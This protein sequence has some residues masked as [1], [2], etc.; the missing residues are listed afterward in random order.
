[1]EKTSFTQQVRRNS[2]ALLSL[3]VALSAL[4]YN[5]WR[6]EATERNRNI[7]VAEFEMLKSLG[8]L[9]QIIDYAHFRR[10]PQRGDL[11]QGLGR[12]LQIHDLATLTPKPVQD[13]AEGLLTAWRK[14]DE[15][16]ATDLEAAGL[17]SEEILHTRRTVLTSLRSLK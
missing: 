5:T 17:I 1:M 11:T 6:N 16:L 15:K 3:C 13:A 2:L 14:H 7:R 4:F 9:Q 10:D 8:E 12:V